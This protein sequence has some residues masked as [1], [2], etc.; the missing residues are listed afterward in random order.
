MKCRPICRS[1]TRP[2]AACGDG[3]RIS[4][5]AN[6]ARHQ[7]NFHLQPMPRCDAPFRPARQL[8]H[9]GQWIKR[10]L[11]RCTDDCANNKAARRGVPSGLDKRISGYHF[12]QGIRGSRIP[13]PCMPPGR[14]HALQPWF[15][16]CRA[17]LQHTISSEL[18]GSCSTDRPSCRTSFE[19]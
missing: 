18:Q 5:P 19:Y 6:V 16:T 12:F 7:R 4:K 14:D 17:R 15:L 10:Q 11:R 9:F 1:A 2:I 13:S 8:L 3:K